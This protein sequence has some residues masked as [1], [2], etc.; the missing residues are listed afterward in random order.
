MI[1]MARIRSIMNWL[2]IKWLP[3]TLSIGSGFLL[4]VLFLL[5]IQ[6]D[7][8]LVHADP[9]MP[10][11]GYPKLSASIK[12]ASPSLVSTGGAK[13]TYTVEI[14]NTGAY[15][16]ADTT[17][18]DVLPEQVTFNEAESSVP[19]AP[20]FDGTTLSWNGEVGFDQTVV[21]SFNVTISPSFSGE[22]INTALISNPMIDEPVSVVATSMVTDDPI[23]TIEKTS[24]PD[25]PGAN[26]PITFTIIVANEGQPAVNLPITVTD[27]VPA[28]TSPRSVGVDGTISPDESFV[29]WNRTS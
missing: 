6:I 22:V 8:D 5:V 11:D 29:T 21:I 23:F 18:T 1:S 15:T 19:P 7:H 13:L 26:K 27:Q 12:T 14:R 24:F 10:P 17:L 28:D 20:Q 16:A 2:P 4:L 25:L 9:I 3:I